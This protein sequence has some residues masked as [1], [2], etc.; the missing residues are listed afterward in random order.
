[1][2]NSKK[3]LITTLLI[4]G[5]LL[6][7]IASIFCFFGPALKMTGDIVQ[8]VSVTITLGSVFPFMFGGKVTMS[9]MGMS[10]TA[11]LESAAAMLT[12]VFVLEV[13]AIILAVIAGIG[14]LTKKLETKKVTVLTCVVSFLMLVGAILALASKNSMITA[15][16]GDPSIVEGLKLGGGIIAYAVLGFVSV[17]ANVAG[18]IVQKKAN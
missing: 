1:M 9:A 6:I 18:I 10:E 4:C 13:I 12:V 14:M 3:G 5:G 17:V 8:G 16:G 15:M 2:M 7:T 11:P